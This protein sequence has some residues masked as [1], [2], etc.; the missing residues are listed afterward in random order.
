MLRGMSM[1]DLAAALITLTALAGFVNQRWFKMPATIGV[2]V[3]GV[4]LAIALLL[5]ERLDFPFAAGL[6]G[7]IKRIDFGATLMDGMLSFLLF[8]GALH[9]DM[10]SLK[11]QR[12]LVAALATLGVVISTL[13]VGLLCW[14]VF[15]R[16]GVPVPL[17]AALLFGALI[18][19]TD[20]IAVLAI[21]RQA[22]IAREL[23]TAIVGESLFND[24]VGL[25]VFLFVLGFASGGAA[26]ASPWVAVG[27]FAQAAGGGLVFGFVLGMAGYALIS[28]VDN[29]RVEVLITLAVVMGGYSA[30]HHLGFSGPIAMVVAGLVIGTHGRAYAMSDLTRARLDDFWE[31]LDEILNAVLFVLIGLEVF[32]VTPQPIYLV[33]GAAAVAIVLVARYLSTLVPVRMLAPADVFPPQFVTVLTWGGLRGGISVAL[34]L[35]LPAGPDKPLLVTVTYCVVLFSI[36]VQG[37]TIGRLVKVLGPKVRE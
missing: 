35:S 15:D 28:R 20:P 22:G 27:L 17:S 37:T 16:L 31:I 33:A 19:P 26:A 32:L 9:V 29:Y 18:S 23:E 3:I 10:G 12:G 34:A 11:T 21:L 36:L 14:V 30:A 4:V 5:L 1:M 2:T 6:T 25:I 8:A 13:C 7:A 24:G